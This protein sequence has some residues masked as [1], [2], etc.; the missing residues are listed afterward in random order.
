MRT[1]KEIYKDVD[2][3]IATAKTILNQPAAGYIPKDR[4]RLS[5]INT[6]LIELLEELKRTH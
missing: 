2:T 5:I 4:L 6:K 3:C 1:K